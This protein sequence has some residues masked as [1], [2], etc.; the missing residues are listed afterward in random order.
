M[1]TLNSAVQALVD[2]LHQKMVD[3]D[4]HNRLDGEEQALAVKAIKTLSEQDSW[5]QSLVGISK[6]HLDTV[7]TAMGQTL[8]DTTDLIATAGADLDSSR[9][10]IDGQKDNLGI[11]AGIDSTAQ[12]ALDNLAASN[13]TALLS[14]L[15]AMPSVLKPVFGLQLIE[16]PSSDITSSRST[17]V[18][19][20]YDNN[21]ESWAVRPGKNYSNVPTES[22]RMEVVKLF[23]DG[24]GQSVFASLY[25]D[26]LTFYD[27]PTTSIYRYGSCAVLPVAH[28][29][30]ATDIHYAVFYSTQTSASV[31]T[32]EYGGVYCASGVAGTNTKPKLN[33]NAKDQW[34]ISTITDH[35]WPDVAC[36]YDNTKHCL[37][38]VDDTTGTL[39]EK[40]R[41]TNV[42]TGITIADDAALQAYVDARDFTTVKFIANQMIEPQANRRSDASLQSI[43]ESKSQDYYG[44]YGKVGTEV[45]MGGFVY[46]AHYRFTAAKKLEPVNY[47][48]ASTV[49][50]YKGSDANGTDGAKADLRVFF[51]DMD[52]NT[53]GAYHYQS[54]C[55]YPG[56]HAGHIGSALMCMNP[57][58][59]VGILNEYGVWDM[60]NTPYY[61][62]ARTCKVF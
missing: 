47:F 60:T 31:E 40:Y 14:H 11:L 51:T 24:A 56:T 62:Q 3:A 35:T 36:L 58:S 46:N 26:H 45:R 9:A 5:Q 18:F 38:M 42:D 22:N 55:D 33:V 39:I 17:A 43:F 54:K 7:N 23:A 27:R 28:S 53:L 4:S 61:G 52:N 20:V 32:S 1:A 37:V 44:F 21:G 15:A 29:G 41:D 6:D 48:F 10:Q 12:T 49:N 25:V 57:Y 59:N 19:V 50:H 30:N 2:N 16:T 13:N 34:G 8:A